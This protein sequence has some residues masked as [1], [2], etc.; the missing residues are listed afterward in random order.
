[1]SG[2]IEHRLEVLLRGE[3]AAAESYHHVLQTIDPNVAPARV[4]DS[5]RE[6]LQEHG[7]AIAFWHGELVS[8]GVEPPRNSGVWGRLA[9]TV[10]KGSAL[11][12]GTTALRTLAQGERV[13]LLRY[14]AAVDEARLPIR[15]LHY[16]QEHLIPR[17]LHNIDHLALLRSA[18]RANANDEVNE[19]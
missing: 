4:E 12:G 7:R 10:T 9:G 14:E 19:G 1:M 15:C 11:V 2:A 6:I 13:G 16:M 3:I 8:R 17:Q 5:L 18:L